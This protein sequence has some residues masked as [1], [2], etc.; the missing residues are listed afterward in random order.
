LF[1]QYQGLYNGAGKFRFTSPTNVL[2]ALKQ[3]LDEYKKEGGLQARRVRYME[4]HRVLTEGLARLGL[5]SIIEPKHQSYII[6][7]FELDDFE[8]SALYGTLKREG[9]IIYPGKLTTMPT[10][11]IGNIGNVYPSDMERLVD[12]IGRQIK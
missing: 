4:N 5:C 12:V 10:F 2:L 6:T 11:R 8:F 3:A 9:F 7:T 1:D